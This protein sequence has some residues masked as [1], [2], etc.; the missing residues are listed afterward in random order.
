[1]IGADL[2]PSQNRLS[3]A[4]SRCHPYL[5]W[6]HRPAPIHTN[7]ALIRMMRGTYDATIHEL[8]WIVDD[9]N[10]L[11]N[12]LSNSGCSRPTLPSTGVD[13]VIHETLD[14]GEDKVVR[15][16]GHL[17]GAHLR[18]TRPQVLTDQCFR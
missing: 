11:E 16:G 10:C 7:A 8:H 4:L 18:V 2:D 3:R 14:R 17:P 5:K 9:I 13:V 6:A 1:M 15:L 12:P